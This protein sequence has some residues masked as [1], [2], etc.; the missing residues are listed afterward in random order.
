VGRKN[1]HKSRAR[2]IDAEF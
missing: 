1:T 2:K